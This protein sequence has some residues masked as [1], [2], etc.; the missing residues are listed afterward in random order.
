MSAA[1]QKVLTRVK[2]P[3]PVRAPVP[4]VRPMLL[5]AAL[6]VGAVN[7]PAEREAEV[8]AAR[9]VASSAPAAPVAAPPADGG[10]PGLRRAAEDQP[11]L[12]QLSE[13]SVPEEHADVE[14]PAA[15]DVAT[16]D[17]ESGDT[18]ELDSGE[19]EDT[20][21]EPEAPDAPPITMF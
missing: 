12:D 15:E 11:N 13:G 8:M 20:S 14:V 7:D 1:K 2:A 6:Q 19:P 5:Q 16:E 18:A 4:V 17:I 9:V 10:P 21:G 3:A